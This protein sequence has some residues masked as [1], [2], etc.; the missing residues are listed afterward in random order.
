TPARKRGRQLKKPF[1]EMPSS[2]QTEIMRSLD[3]M[4]RDM[5]TWMNVGGTSE[6]VRDTV[7]AAKIAPAMPKL[8]KAVAD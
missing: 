8:F 5:F 1:W 7:T 3:D 6:L 4:F 2:T